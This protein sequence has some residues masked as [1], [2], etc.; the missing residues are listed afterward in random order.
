MPKADEILVRIHASAVTSS[1]WFIRSAIPSF[2]LRIQLAM[3][4]MVGITAPRKRIL[5][6][7]LA[8]QVDEIGSSVTRFTVGERVYAFTKFHF[9]S[10]AQY[11]CLTE[12]STVATAPANVT[13]EEA[14]AIPYGGLLALHY[15]RKGGVGHGTAVL[16]YGASG[17]VGSSAVQLAR[18]LGGEVTAVCGPANLELV[19]SLGASQVIDYTTESTLGIEQR[20]DLVFDAVGKRK[21]SSLKEAA[22]TGLRPGGRFISV[23]DGTPDL[24]AT[25]LAYLT[26]LVE[27]GELQPVIDRRYRLDEIVEAHR[28]VEQEHKRG[29]VVITVA[30]VE[31]SSG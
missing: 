14:A 29:N 4:L 21:S 1:D 12:S 22:R 17:A 11:T 15:L 7:I 19:R 31:T 6:L 8:G 18:H 26:R 10:Y 25:D 16:V 24:P 2:P 27:A 20:Y 5:G 9:G 13:L 23:D 3:R 28:Y 30:H